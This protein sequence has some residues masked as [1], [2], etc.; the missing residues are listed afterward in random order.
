MNLNLANDKLNLFKSL[1]TGREDVFAIRW[2]KGNKSRQSFLENQPES[3]SRLLHDYTEER[4]G[5]VNWKD[6]LE[7]RLI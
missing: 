1:F 7:E 5:F 4:K 2:E 6:H 3:F